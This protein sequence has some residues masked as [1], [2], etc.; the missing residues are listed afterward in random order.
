V[1]DFV[2]SGSVFAIAILMHL[3]TKTKTDF[4][5]RF[6]PPFGSKSVCPFQGLPVAE[7]FLRGEIL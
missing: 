7:E 1:C 6:A 4:L 5:L 3:I 2:A